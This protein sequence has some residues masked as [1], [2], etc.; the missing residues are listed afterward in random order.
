[1]EQYCITLNTDILFYIMI[2]YVIIKVI[3]LILTFIIEVKKDY[4]N[5]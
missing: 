1:M 3:E 5:K 4:Q 2:A